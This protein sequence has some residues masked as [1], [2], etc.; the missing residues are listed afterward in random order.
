MIIQIGPQRRTVSQDHQLLAGMIDP[1]Q[2]RTEAE[3]K[4][5]PDQAD[6]GLI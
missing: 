3:T 4:K 1:V 6:Q 5:N 2:V